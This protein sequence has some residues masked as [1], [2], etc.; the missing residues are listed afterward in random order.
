MYINHFILNSH[1]KIH[2]CSYIHIYYIHTYIHTYAVPPLIKVYICCIL[3]TYI[4]TYIHTH[5]MEPFASTRSVYPSMP[6]R[7]MRRPTSA[8]FSR[9]MGSSLSLLRQRPRS[10]LTWFAIDHVIYYL[11]FVNRLSTAYLNRCYN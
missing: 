7:R 1:I 2:V 8:S 10:Y 9:D 5:V 3:H 4:H 11:I 6:E